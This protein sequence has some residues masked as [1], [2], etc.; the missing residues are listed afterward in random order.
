[1]HWTTNE[2]FLWIL[3]GQMRSCYSLC[4]VEVALCNPISS[5]SLPP[6]A[7]S[8]FTCMRCQVKA[9][10]FTTSIPQVKTNQ[11]GLFQS[12]LTCR[13][14]NSD[15]IQGYFIQHSDF[16]LL[17][18]KIWFLFCVELFFFVN[19]NGRFTCLLCLCDHSLYSNMR[20]PFFTMRGRQ[21]T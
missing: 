6:P 13:L 10:C 18:F 15:C 19:N 21:S 3:L 12:N 20:S 2:Q 9:H 11:K 14:T 16:P 17:T 1:M 8:C 7:H 5:S 4:C